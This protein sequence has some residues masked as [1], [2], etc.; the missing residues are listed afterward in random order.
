MVLLMEG[1][2]RS[3]QYVKRVPRRGPTRRTKSNC[4]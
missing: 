3:A 2:Y 4:G 1:K